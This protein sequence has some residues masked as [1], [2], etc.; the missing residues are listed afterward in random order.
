MGMYFF[1]AFVYVW[2]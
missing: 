1:P 2:V